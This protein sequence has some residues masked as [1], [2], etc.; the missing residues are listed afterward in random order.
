M[1][2]EH[3]APPRAFAVR[4]LAGLCLATLLA[5]LLTAPFTDSVVPYV[6]DPAVLGLVP[7][8]GHVHR[9]RAEGWGDSRF[10]RFGVSVHDDVTALRG[11]TV[12]I[13]GDS[14][15]EAWQVDDPDKVAAQVTALCGAD[16]LTGVG[17]GQSGRAAADVVFLL[18]RYEKL[19]SPEAHYIVLPHLSDV[20]PDGLRFFDDP[21]RLVEVP[22]TAG[23]LGL[24]PI[25][26]R[27]HLQLFWRAARTAVN[28]ADGNR[29][30][31]LRPGPVK[32]PG[33]GA[34]GLGGTKYDR[35]VVLPSDATLEYLLAALDAATERPLVFIYTPAVPRIR[36]NAV[37]TQDQD[38]AAARHVAALAARRG[39]GFLDLSAA[40][41]RAY[42][43]TGEFPR[44]FHNGVPGSGHWNALG[45]RLVAEA[46]CADR[47]D[48]A[49]PG[50][51]SSAP[52]A[53]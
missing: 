18:P 28:G 39:I 4:W 47:A 42:Q 14:Y 53:R 26:E 17:V 41:V 30:V 45:H 3:D 13:W 21:P 22:F 19:F 49:R 43:Q 16:G 6:N 36:A 2:T 48:R 1:F 7:V 27:F 15:V 38:A 23:S 46:I 10:G 12:A 25:L 52:G 20:L 34:G 51:G 35:P 44:G 33:A 31:R 11:P 9:Q 32:R 40:F 29:V 37:E 5:A 50:G 24:R 8:P